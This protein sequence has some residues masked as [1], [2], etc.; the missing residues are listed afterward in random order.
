M[1]EALKLLDSLL[2]YLPSPSMTSQTVKP[3][4]IVLKKTHDKYFC[5]GIPQK[6]KNFQLIEIPEILTT[7]LKKNEILVQSQY[8]SGKN[9]TFH[10]SNLN[11]LIK[12]CTINT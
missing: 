6:D 11:F 8:I 1:S 10:N 3:L 5:D 12:F 4:R 7:E 9:L 2:A